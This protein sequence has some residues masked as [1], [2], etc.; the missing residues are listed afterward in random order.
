M[1]WDREAVAEEKLAEKKPFEISKEIIT[2][3]EDEESQYILSRETPINEIMMV[4]NQ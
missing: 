4:T 3:F 1:W 2:S